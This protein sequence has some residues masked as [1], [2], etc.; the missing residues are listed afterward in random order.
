MPMVTKWRSDPFVLL[1]LMTLSGV[2]WASEWYQTVSCT[3][4][5]P[6]GF[7]SQ[8]GV[9]FPS[10][11]LHLE[12]R[13]ATGYLYAVMP[14]AQVENIQKQASHLLVVDTHKLSSAEA[15]SYRSIFKGKGEQQIPW[16]VGAIG[17]LPTTVT[18]ALGITVT[19][20]DG[21][22]RID[23][24]RRDISAEQLSELMAADG[25]FDLAYAVVQDSDK[26][27]YIVSSVIYRVT[28]G[29]EERSY[30]LSSSSFALKITR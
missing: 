13:P 20:I 6:F 29:R 12:G 3:I 8:R 1:L 19:L 11:G 9:V 24:S 15:A 22:Q 2:S 23:S 27:N 17:A 18:A 7:D 4:N 28:V 14:Q 5:D 25:V 16:V 30:V 10:S 21:L 26:H